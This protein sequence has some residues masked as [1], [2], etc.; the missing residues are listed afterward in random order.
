MVRNRLKRQSGV[1]CQPLTWLSCSF[2]ALTAPLNLEQMGQFKGSW[3]LAWRPKDQHSLLILFQDQERGDMSLPGHYWDLMGLCGD[4]R[5]FPGFCWRKVPLWEWTLLGHLQHASGE[6]RLQVGAG[7]PG[8]G[9]PLIA[10]WGVLFRV[11]RAPSNL[12]H[13][14]SVWS[15][16]TWQP[17]R[18]FES[19]HYSLISEE[20]GGEEWP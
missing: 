6:E 8:V 5:G 1:K 16:D 19:A 15:Q 10:W 2:H 12:E 3:A 18:D 17:S 4:H 9:L 7:C 11:S 20:P 14:D 13:K